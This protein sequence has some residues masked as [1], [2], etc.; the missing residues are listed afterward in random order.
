MCGTVEKS[1]DAHI[2]RG[3]TPPVYILFFFFSA[4]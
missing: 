3:S 2:D 1:D 4:S